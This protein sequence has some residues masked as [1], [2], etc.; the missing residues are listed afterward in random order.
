[1]MQFYREINLEFQKFIINKLKKLENM[2]KLSLIAILILIKSVAFAQQLV[3][4]NRNAPDR[5]GERI[6]SFSSP[7]EGIAKK[8]IEVWVYYSDNKE[9]LSNPD[10]PRGRAT[11]SKNTSD[12]T[13]LDCRFYFPHSDHMK[14]NFI[15][16]REREGG[17]GLTQTEAEEFLL[18]LQNPS[19]IIAVGNQYN[20]LVDYS[21]GI[22]D[23]NSKSYNNPNKVYYKIIRKNQNNKKES[24]VFEFTMPRVFVIGYMGDSYAS[25]E[26]AP[27]SGNDKWDDDFCHRSEKSGGM[28]GINK[29]MD[30]RRDL[31]VRVINTTCSGAK[32][33]NLISNRHE[34]GNA[35]RKPQLDQIADWM[36]T[37]NRE[38]IDI[39]LMGIGGNSINF[40]PMATAALTPPLPGIDNNWLD[41][42]SQSGKTV[43]LLR[44]LPG[45]YDDL[46]DAL[47]NQEYTIGK[48]LI[49]NYPNMLFGPGKKLCDNN[50]IDNIASACRGQ[51]VSNQLFSHINFFK[52]VLTD[53]NEEIRKASERHGWEVI[54]VS[55]IN[56][57]GLCNCEEPYFNN[58]VSSMWNQGP[59]D[60]SGA[61]HPN[62]DGYKE[63]YMDNVYTALKNAIP[64]VQLA[65]WKIRKEE[66]KADLKAKA[67]E[68]LLK[69]AEKAIAQKKLQEKFKAELATK[70][71]TFLDTVKIKM[72]PIVKS[73]EVSLKNVDNPRPR[74]NEDN[75]KN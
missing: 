4:T 3:I 22:T 34:K 62:A 11:C 30:R 45:K 57:H 43:D 29:L 64:D 12:P 33:G 20:P 75:E 13:N 40:V 73:S 37:K 26:G 70:A 71:E 67:K 5:V 2:K 61:I 48:V 59:G 55:A 18:N 49:M 46:N 31:A 17:N 50:L 42:D 19:S 60:I 69:K 41:F 44:E 65:D 39:M 1:M 6:L 66:L 14:P 9:Q 68:D 63:L 35:S 16:K 25:G 15:L 38:T 7:L 24:Q 54:R 8:D 53:L 10:C 47:I 23:K 28:R 56:S 36:K 51:I 27:K 52:S 58:L 32:I 21:A 74:K 72:P